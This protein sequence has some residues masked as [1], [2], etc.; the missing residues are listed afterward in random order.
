MAIAGLNG[1]RH[2][3]PKVKDKE[4]EMNWARDKRNLILLQPLFVLLSVLLAL[5]PVSTHGAEKPGQTPKKT[6]IVYSSIS[7]NM[8]PLWV[9][10]ERGFFRKYALDVELIL[11]EG[12]SR[13]AQ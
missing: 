6:R 7:G 5:F 1:E 2:T 11:V 3:A 12:G 9:T 13:A 10:Y 4:K 8:A